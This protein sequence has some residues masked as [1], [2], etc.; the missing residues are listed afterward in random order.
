MLVSVSLGCCLDGLVGAI[1]LRA[2]MI[3]VLNCFCL[4]VQAVSQICRAIDIVGSSL[5]SR[6][7]S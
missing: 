7:S 4:I 2:A 6:V 5:T 3:V 1:L